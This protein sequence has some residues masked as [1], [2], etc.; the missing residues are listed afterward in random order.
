MIFEEADDEALL[1]VL[2]VLTTLALELDTLA[3]DWVGLLV[4]LTID[5]GPVGALK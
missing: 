4:S 3:L 5:A 1:L 2:F